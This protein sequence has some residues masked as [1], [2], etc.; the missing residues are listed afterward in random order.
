MPPWIDYKHVWMW[1]TRMASVRAY[2]TVRQLWQ[3]SNRPY[4]MTQPSMVYT[5]AEVHS[6]GDHRIVRKILRNNIWDC[7]I[8][9]EVVVRPPHWM[10]VKSYFWCSVQRP[11]DLDR[12]RSID[13]IGNF[14][15]SWL[16]FF[17]LVCQW[18]SSIELCWVSQSCNT[19]NQTCVI[20]D[21]TLLSLLQKV[22]PQKVTIAIH[23]SFLWGLQIL[24]FCD[25]TIAIVWG[26]CCWHQLTKLVLLIAFNV[27]LVS[28][29]Q[30]VV[31]MISKRSRHQL[32]HVIPAW[33]ASNILTEEETCTFRL[34]HTV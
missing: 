1:I 11:I 26:C 33:L 2:N 7:P 32:L 28:L 27:L 17:T 10:I 29:S 8:S 14:L 12:L 16:L 22:L 13:E 24:Y 25:I 6:L 31:C 34:R 23:Q 19:H 20:N 4:N 30:Q 9:M 18:F 21:V 5:W 15:C 3:T